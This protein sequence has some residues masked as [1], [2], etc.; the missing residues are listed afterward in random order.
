MLNMKQ[1]Y[2]FLA[3]MFF[4]SVHACENEIDCNYLTQRAFIL[5]ERAE[6]MPEGF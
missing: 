2:F 1:V 6:A 5:A 3:A 4:G